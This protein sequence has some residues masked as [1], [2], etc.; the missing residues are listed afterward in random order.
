MQHTLLTPLTKGVY[1]FRNRVVMAPMN[2][3]RA[4]DGVPGHAMAT[5]Y[6]Q[7]AGAGLIVTDNTAIAPNAIGYLNTPGLYTQAQRDGW[8][9]IVET[10]HHENGTIFIQLVH[11]G[12]IGHPANHM[13]GLPLVG[14]SD[15]KAN[16]TVRTPTGHLPMPEPVVLTQPEV[17]DLVALHVEA[18]AMAVALGFDGVE[19]HGAH[20]FLPEQ[21]LNPQTNNRTDHYGG[22]LVKRSRFILEIMEGVVGA[23]G[24]ERTGIRLSPFASVNDL[25]PYPDELETH[26]YLV[27]ALAA[28]NIGFLHLSNQVVNGISSI[29][30]A[31]LI[32]VRRRFKNLLIFTG[33]NT[34]E[35]AEQ[36]I[37]SELID[38]AGFGKPF[39]A[40]P[41][42]PERFRHNAALAVPDDATF[43]T[44]GDKGYTDYASF[45][46][47]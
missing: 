16:E 4:V 27:N 22:S 40:N 29:P 3:R 46:T 15:R 8:K 12:R 44:E 17:Q 13:G 35:S 6:H 45:T 21:F 9:R 5:Y 10:V 1:A 14:A 34:R 19:I 26:R 25:S 30:H 42:L 2:R 39:I 28:M 24:A 43:Y 32:E 7:R 18:A 36:L 41:D 20:G 38:L 11:T 47:A 23:I 31:Y 33:G 37:Q